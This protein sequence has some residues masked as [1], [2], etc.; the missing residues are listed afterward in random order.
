MDASRDITDRSHEP[1]WLQQQL[2]PIRERWPLPQRRR[3]LLDLTIDT[4]LDSIDD[5]LGGL[6]AEV[7]FWT[8]LSLGPLLLTIIATLSVVADAAHTTWADDTIQWIHV[9]TTTAFGTDVHQALVGPMLT[10]ITAEAR[11]GLLGISTLLAIWSASRAIRAV[12]AAVSVAYD[13]RDTR[14][15]VQQRLLAIALTIGGLLVGAII[16]PVLLA[17]PRL[18]HTLTNWLGLTNQ[19]AM[20]WQIVY[21]PTAAAVLLAL[22]TTTYHLAAPWW[23]PWRRDLP[24]ATLT[25]ILWLAAA[26]GFRQYLTATFHSSSHGPLAAPV[27]LLLWSYLTAAALL[28]GAELNAEIEKRW[29]TN[30]RPWHH[31]H[32]HRAMAAARQLRQHSRH[33]NRT[34]NDS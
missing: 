5:R 12:L 27:A 8:T 2:H 13:L 10:S 33:T 21:W 19:L 31:T 23:T 15:V 32:V 18:G 26:A 16:I 29:P 28:V 30:H 3:H 34:T 17:G 22:L 1:T 24:G 6:A 4:I 11:H 20:L 9:A 7:A 14:N 25:V